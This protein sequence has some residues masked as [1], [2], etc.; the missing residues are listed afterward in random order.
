MFESELEPMAVSY[1]T[2]AQ[3]LEELQVDEKELKRLVSNAELRGFRA[4]PS[5]KF[6]ADDVQALKRA[7]AVTPPMERPGARPVA[8]DTEVTDT[9][10]DPREIIFTEGCAT[11]GGRTR[12]VVVIPRAPVTM[13]ER[14]AVIVG[15]SQFAAP[16]VP[17]LPCAERDARDLHDVLTDPARAGVDPGNVKMLLGADATLDAVKRALGVFLERSAAEDDLVLLYFATHG[18]VQGREGYLLLHDSDP[19]APFRTALR[20]GELASIL[21]SLSTGNVVLI[22]DACHAGATT[23]SDA[24][25][26]VLDGFGASA[27]SR[28]VLAACGAAE[29][30]L[31]LEGDVNG[32]FT[33]HL[34]AGLRGEADRGREGAV[35]VEDLFS[36]VRDH[37]RDEAARIGRQQT[38]SWWGKVQSPMLLAHDP[39]SQ[40]PEMGKIHRRGVPRLLVLD[41]VGPRVRLRLTGKSTTIGRHPDCDLQ[42]LGDR[43]VSRDHAQIE[44]RQGEYVLTT[45][46]PA[47]RT[48]RNGVPI[49]P[50][51]PQVLAGGDELRLGSTRLLFLWDG[52]AS[53]SETGAVEAHPELRFDADVLEVDVFSDNIATGLHD[54]DHLESI[55]C[56][57]GGE[58]ALLEADLFTGWPSA[59]PGAAVPDV[60]P[61]TAV[62]DGDADRDGDARAGDLIDPGR[63]ASGPPLGSRADSSPVSDSG[64]VG[65]TTRGVVGRVVG[66]LAKFVFGAPDHVEAKQATGPEALVMSV[67]GLSAALRAMTHG[68]RVEDRATEWLS[69]L[70]VVASSDRGLEAVQLASRILGLGAERLQEA[71]QRAAGR[72]PWRGQARPPEKAA[73]DL[74]QGMLAIATIGGELS[75]RDRA[76]LFEAASW[77]RVNHRTL[78]AM[79][80]AALPPRPQAGEF[81]LVISGLSSP[82][83]REAAVPAIAEVRGCSPQEA[84]D[85]ARSPVIVVL[86]DTTEERV[87]SAKRRFEEL[88]IP[89]RVTHRPGTP[90]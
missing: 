55:N 37:V 66:T 17:A 6:K 74:L 28:V 2:F 31:E 22:L 43:G 1:L 21:D 9:I 87:S 71:L 78:K 42:L 36:Y 24:W 20:M 25:F 13:A 50:G 69:V 40:G 19:A 81:G 90:G 49:S 27:G 26:R 83:R 59:S 51:D 3:T 4:G 84:R 34:L 30:S 88:G 18:V 8:D 39:V 46:G 32:L 67:R 76:A 45:Q 23:P 33:K 14:H 79:V 10:I 86:R 54:V 15:V 89:A 47:N 57:D 72:H 16:S 60:A 12:D 70:A 56:S 44:R 35:G 11:R 38:P 77:A 75:A 80:A 41:E 7:R 64:P 61:T 48:S 58:D 82:M 68:E 62:D 65:A 73:L 29:Q 53:P 5:M 85:L 63:Q 52:T